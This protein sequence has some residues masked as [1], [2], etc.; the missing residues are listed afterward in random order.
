MQPVVLLE[1]KVVC[2]VGGGSSFRTDQESHGGNRDGATLARPIRPGAAQPII[3]KMRKST[4]SMRLL[5]SLFFH[6]ARFSV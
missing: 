6:V 3:E 5:W 1:K 4:P 2:A